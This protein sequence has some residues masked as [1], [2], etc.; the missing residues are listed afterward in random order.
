MRRRSQR[1]GRNWAATMGRSSM[2]PGFLGPING[3]RLMGMGIF[4][5]KMAYDY[6]MGL[7]EIYD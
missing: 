3:T 2:C 7:Y 6:I 4:F 1:P 5:K